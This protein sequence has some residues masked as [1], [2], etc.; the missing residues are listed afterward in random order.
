[1]RYFSFG[2]Q[3]KTLE[4]QK[5][6]F[7]L[8]KEFFLSS[9]FSNFALRSSPIFLF[10][11][12]ADFVEKVDWFVLKLCSKVYGII[13]SLNWILKKHRFFNI[14]WSKVLILILGH[15]QIWLSLGKIWSTTLA[16]RQFCLLNVKHF[17]LFYMIQRPLRDLKWGWVANLGQPH[18]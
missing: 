2:H 14:W 13:G 10:L 4:N 11:A 9:S 6:I 12:I 18:I 5:K 7:F 8:P 1:M 3:I 15:G 17:P 16:E